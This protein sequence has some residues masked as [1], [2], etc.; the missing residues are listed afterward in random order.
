MIQWDE[1]TYLVNVDWFTYS[2]DET[3]EGTIY[4]FTVYTT[5]GTEHTKALTDKDQ[6]AALWD[7]LKT[8]A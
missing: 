4:R 5:D 1:R 6:A 7:L 2:E 8:Y 3:E